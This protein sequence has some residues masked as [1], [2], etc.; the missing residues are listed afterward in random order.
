MRHK[1]RCSIARAIQWYGPDTKVIGETA[2]I[3]SQDWIPDKP[4]PI[5]SVT[6]VDDTC[7]W[8][9]AELLKGLK[10][11]LSKGLPYQV[12]GHKRFSTRHDAVDAL[13]QPTPWETGSAIE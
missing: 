6:V 10:Y 1:D 3:T 2:Q 11:P 9:E 13:C 12:D 4:I 5:T 7:A 8:S